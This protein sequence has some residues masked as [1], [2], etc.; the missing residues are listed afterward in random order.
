MR[1]Q[2]ISA[3]R[4]PKRI[5]RYAFS[6]DSASVWTGPE[7]I[8]PWILTRLIFLLRMFNLTK[9]CRP[10]LHWRRFFWIHNCFRI[11]C[12]YSIQIRRCLQ[13]LVNARTFIQI[14]S[15]YFRSLRI[16]ISGHVTKREGVFQILSSLH[17]RQNESVVP[18]H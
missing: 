16:K 11:Y 12:T 10:G 1:F 5:E 15:I 3:H 7:T 17:K 14:E 13:K 18:T 2:R 4:R 8:G 9:C 6:N